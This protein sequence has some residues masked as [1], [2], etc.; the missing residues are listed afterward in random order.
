[1]T[2]DKPVLAY[3]RRHRGKWLS[4]SDVEG[5]LKA[6]GQIDFS[7]A[8]V[9]MSLRHR[10]I[11]ESRMEGRQVLYRLPPTEPD[12]VVRPRPPLPRARRSF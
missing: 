12:E 5:A 8:G 6:K 9:L 10:E 2:A 7:I 1:M 4:P 3:F 11:I